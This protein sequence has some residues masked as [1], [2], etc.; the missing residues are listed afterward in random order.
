M[1]AST[2]IDVN[3]L[4]YAR[5]QWALNAG[6]PDVKNIPEPTN[7]DLSNINGEEYASILKLTFGI[8]FKRKGLKIPQAKECAVDTNNDT[9][10]DIEGEFGTDNMIGD[11]IFSIK[12][13]AHATISGLLI[14]DGDRMKADILVD[15]WSDQTQ[16]GSVAD[17]T[18]LKHKTGRDINVVKRY[19]ASKIIGGK[20]IKVLWFQSV[21]LTAYVWL[22]WIVRK[23]LRIPNG[24][25]G[26]SWL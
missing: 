14:G 4:S 22:K 17:L 12:G 20:N 1:S 8:I 11:Q 10:I 18:N 6:R 21:K 24:Q 3:Y 7:F 13:N 19:F 25:K 23:I 2:R 9:I 15:N 26:P 16:K 5:G